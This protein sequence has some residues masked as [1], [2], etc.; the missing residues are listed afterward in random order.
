MKA[1]LDRLDGTALAG[2]RVTVHTPDLAEVF[3]ALTGHPRAQQGG[4]E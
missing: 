4:K 2:P 3:F 1:L